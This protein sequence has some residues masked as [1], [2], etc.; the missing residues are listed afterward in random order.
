M[1]KDSYGEN[2]Q[3]KN[4]LL[5][6]IIIFTLL[7]FGSVSATQYIANQFSFNP[8]LGTPVFGE[9]YNPMSWVIWSLEYSAYYPDFFKYFFLKITAA[10]AVI[11]SIVN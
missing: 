6:I 1:E 10:I 3:I 5:S 8:A 11:F 9:Y 7:F 4:Y 2:T